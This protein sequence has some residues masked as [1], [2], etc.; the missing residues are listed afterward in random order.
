MHVSSS[1]GWR[2]AL[3]GVCALILAFVAPVAA[4][5]P[6]PNKAQALVE[7]VTGRVLEVLDKHSG[8]GSMDVEQVKDELDDIVFPHMDFVTMTKLAVGHYWRQASD[9]Q[10]RTLVNE[11]RNLLVRTYSTSLD[12]YQDHK[13]EFL[14][15]RP[16]PYDDRVTV[17]SR[18]LRPDGPPIAVNY[19]MR[20]NDG[21]WKV[22]DIVVE[23]ISLVT[24]YQSQFGSTVQRDGIAGLI[25]ELERKNERGEVSSEAPGAE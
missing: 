6:D 4:A 15:L 19:G 11:F 9:E 8:S 2:T 16:S 25:A 14:P 10:K 13:L 5:K 7:D 1:N 12:E 3:A 20:Y 22:Y 18:V 24:T 17:R 21:A 23:E